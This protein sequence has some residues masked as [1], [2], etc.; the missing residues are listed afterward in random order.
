MTIDKWIVLVVAI[1]VIVGL[2]VNFIRRMNRRGR[3]DKRDQ[4]PE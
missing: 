4:P 2:N 3:S 1:C